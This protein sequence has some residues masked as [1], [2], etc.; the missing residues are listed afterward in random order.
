[1]NEIEIIISE[2]E[3]LLINNILYS[4]LKN[5]GVLC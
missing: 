1:M 2:I 5:L 4:I 3:K